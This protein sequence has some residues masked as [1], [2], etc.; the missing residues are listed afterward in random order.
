MAS[1][2]F[3]RKFASS[4]SRRSTRIIGRRR[5]THLDLLKVR[6]R[7]FYVPLVVLQAVLRE[8]QVQSCAQN[9]ILHQ[10]ALSRWLRKH[11]SI[12]AMT[13]PSSPPKIRWARSD[14]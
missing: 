13:D 2:S 5:R 14:G 6:H 1:S 12:A 8:L 4:V 9:H 7:L 11:V 10:G 3:K